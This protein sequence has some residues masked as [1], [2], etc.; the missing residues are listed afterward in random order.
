MFAT[1]AE[2]NLPSRPQ[3]ENKNNDAENNFEISH[4][5]E[6]FPAGAESRFRLP[7]RLFGERKIIPQS[8]SYPA[9]ALHQG[10]VDTV[11]LA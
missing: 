11:F 7:C 2:T 6:T 10:N 9:L 5:L 3:R 8:R 4:D 1:T